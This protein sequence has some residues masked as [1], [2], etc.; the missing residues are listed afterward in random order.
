MNFL[1]NFF[2]KIIVVYL[3][4]IIWLG[5]FIAYATSDQEASSGC[6]GAY[7]SA[8]EICRNTVFG[9]Y[10]TCN[11]YDE[12]SYACQ[13][14]CSARNREC[15][16]GINNQYTAC[17][18]G[19]NKQP[20]TTQPAS[21]PVPP[22]NQ[23]DTQP[24]KTLEKERDSFTQE[25]KIRLD[26]GFTERVLTVNGTIY[27]PALVDVAPTEGNPT[28]HTEWPAFSSD[29]Q[30]RLQA[31]V[32]KLDGTADMQLSDGTWV[33]VEEGTIIPYGATIF[34]GYAAE[35]E[36]QFSQYTIVTLRSLAELNIEQFA[37]DASVYRKELKLETGE[38]R[39][40][41]FEPGIKTDMKVQTPNYTASP[42]GTDFGVFYDKNAG[43]TLY[44]IYDGVIEVESL[45]TGE[46]R[47]LSSTYG[48]PI[49]RIEGTQDGTMTE[50]IAIPQSEW[51]VFVAK[52]KNKKSPATWQWI[53][54]L[55]IIGSIGY[56][57]YRKKDVLVNF[58]KK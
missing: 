56:L 32:I 8:R 11:K 38:L 41:V 53:V 36:L 19:I 37:K 9:C 29:D 28:S 42:A 15:I 47:V 1:D 4:A 21:Q 24:D 5:G 43:I 50:K 7:D 27:V 14:A 35:A 39:F 22:E 23:I 12:G 2:L 6:Q 54:T 3:L 10:D 48:S 40:K 20:P 33:V 55:L 17:V 25:P 46:K 16:E 51:D 58:F 34:T 52:A 13:N 44:E 49:K 57:A 18:E 26:T 30:G 45:A 31:R